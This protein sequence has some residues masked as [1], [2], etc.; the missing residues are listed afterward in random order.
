MNLILESGNFVAKIS[1]RNYD[2]ESLLQKTYHLGSWES[3][4]D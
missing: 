1:Q 2:E 4:N 3:V